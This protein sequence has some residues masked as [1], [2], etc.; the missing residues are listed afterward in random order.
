MENEDV[1][2]QFLS[3]NKN[4]TVIPIDH[5]G[6]GIS[7]GLNTLPQAAR[8]FPHLA[9]G[10]G[11]FIALLE[12]SN[13][14]AASG[15][16]KRDGT[17]TIPKEF[18]EFCK[19]YI[20]NVDFTKGHIVA[21]GVNLYRQP[22]QLDLRG[23]RVAR[24]GW[25]L[26]ECAK[27]RFVPSHALAMGLQKDNFRYTVELSEENANRY[28][29]GESLDASGMLDVGLNNKPWVVVCYES[30]PLGWARLVQMRLKNN[31][32]VGLVVK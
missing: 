31:L 17:N 27:G 32:P 12:K 21:N 10:E 29:R 30:F 8:I 14:G 11:H 19:E 15:R 18:T 16:S 3:E 1:I 6:L 4:F 24:S 22:E 9:T 26:G 23:I 28:L 7:Q 20:I 5:T 13:A 2:I 25:H